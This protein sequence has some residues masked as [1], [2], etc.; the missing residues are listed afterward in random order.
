MIQYQVFQGF[1]F[2]P[3]H[4]SEKCE[5]FKG[6]KS[7]VEGNILRNYPDHLLDPVELIAKVKPV[8][9]DFPSCWS[10]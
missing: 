4:V 8:N 3:K 6:S 9:P 10:N 2:Q 1:S 5:V 7:R